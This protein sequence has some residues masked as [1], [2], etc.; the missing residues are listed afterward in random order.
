M[1]CDK[2]GYESSLNK[3]KW[4]LI[5]CEI[6]DIFSP[7]DQDSFRDY[8]LEKIDGST[9]ETFRKNYVSNSEKQKKTMLKKATHGRLMSRAPFG[10]KIEKGNLI[11][12]E[13]Q[14]EV[15]EIFEEFLNE[16][17]SLRR[18]SEKRNLSVNGLK[19]ILKNFTYIGKV[20][21]NNQIYQGNHKPLISAIL[22]NR[23]QDKLERM[24]IK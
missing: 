3:N 10:Y 8:M 18:L 22:F 6:C 5:I 15:E 9:L 11:P 20:K 19:K 16:D 12:S 13:N 17:I 21:F 4:G 2:C 14:K 24:K 23:V 7:K 1:K